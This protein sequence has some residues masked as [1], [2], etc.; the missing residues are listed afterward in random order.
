[1]VFDGREDQHF[2]SPYN[3]PLVVEL[4]VTNALVRQILIDTGNSTDIIPW[5]CLKGHKHPG[6]EITPLVHPIPG[7][8]G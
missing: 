7:F 5:D 2:I 1:M 6:R 4:K 3:D 8:G